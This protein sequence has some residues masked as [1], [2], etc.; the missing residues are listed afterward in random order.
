MGG[1]CAYTELRVEG[2]GG[3]RGGRHEEKIRK[4][5]ARGKSENREAARSGE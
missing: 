4:N 3:R 2:R 1:R 5:K